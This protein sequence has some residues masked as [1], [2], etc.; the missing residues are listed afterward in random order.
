M[1]TP[2]KDLEETK[3]AEAET[4]A[5]VA[6]PDEEIR[7][8]QL[9][10]TLQPHLEQGRKKRRRKP[11]KTKKPW[12]QR[13]AT[14]FSLLVLFAILAVL[15]PIALALVAGRAVKAPEFLAVRVEKVLGQSLAGGQ[16]DLGRIDVILTEEWQPQIR[17]ERLAL[18]DQT[19]LPIAE[20]R[21]IRVTLSRRELLRATV[22][23]LDVTVNGGFMALRRDPDG[24]FD[25]ALESPDGR[26]L[27][28]TGNL[29]D[30]L[31]GIDR[32]FETPELA[33]V[34][35][36][37]AE[38]F[39][40]Q[41]EDVRA[42]KFWIAEGGAFE[43]T[44]QP[45]KLELRLGFQLL[46]GED[47][48]AQAAVSFTSFKGSR[49]AVLATNVI[50]L[51]ASD[52]ASQAPAL[53]W[54]EVLDAPVSGA[55]RAEIDDEGNLAST[56][57]T[58]D[59]GAGALK[60]TED[61]VPVG[62]DGARAYFGFD[63]AQQRIHF[64][65]LSV[66]TDYGSFQ[67]SGQGLLRDIR[68]GWPKEILGQFRLDTLELSPDGVFA[69]PVSIDQGVVELRLELNP[70]TLTLGQAMLQQGDGHLVARGQVAAKPGGWEVSV[71]AELDQM[72]ARSV[73]A[74][75]PL[76]A[77]GN[78]RKWLDANILEGVIGPAS[79]ALRLNPGEKPVVTAQFG[80][81]D[82]AVRF[83]RQMPLIT[84]GRG[85]GSLQGNRFVLV[86]E[87]GQVAPPEGGAL[88]V[89]GSVMTLE[90]IS[91]RPPD[92]HVDLQAQGNITAVTSLLD[93]RPFEFF[94]KAELPVD[95]A[96]GTAQVVADITVPLR[97][98][99]QAEDVPFEARATLRNMGTREIVP[100]KWVLADAM[101]VFANNEQ[102]EIS[103]SGF[104]AKAETATTGARFD[105]LWQQSLAPENAGQSSV[106]GQVILDQAFLDE[107]GIALPDGFLRGESRGE[108]AIDLRRDE[109]PHMR[110]SSD[111]RGARL[112]IGEIGWSKPASS[113]GSLEISGHLGAP[114]RID[115]LQLE[116][117]G[118]NAVG[119]VVLNDNNSF[120]EA[121]FDR[122]TVG[123]WLD[124]PVTL[125]ARNAGQSPAISVRGGRVDIR[126]TTFGQGGSAGTGSSNTPITLALD[127][128]QITDSIALH[129]M[130]GQLNTSPALQGD[131]TG[132]VNGQASVSGRLS[133]SVEGTSVR[134]R[135]DD[136]GAVLR[137]AGV[138]S[139]VYGG[140]MDMFL[141][142]RAEEGHY[143]GR[144]TAEGIKIRGAPALAEILGAISVVGLLQQLNGDGIRFGSVQSHFVLT[145]SYVNLLDGSAIGASLGVSM[146]GIY[147]LG[148]SGLDLRGVVSPIYLLN[149]VGAAVSRRREGLF[150][151]NYRLQ[152]TA[153]DPKVR[154]NPL[155]ILTPGILRD[156]FRGRAPEVP[157]E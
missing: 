136:S 20:L 132:L 21:N 15:V 61:T 55:L 31:D 96:T 146:E 57:G 78:T 75:W 155:S 86:A 34:R 156:V 142:P 44:Q 105:A 24:L 83:M 148:T 14:I 138:F 120:R 37:S 88:Q 129:N 93:Q 65:E 25:M 10:A 30:I 79:A 50:G 113:G 90:D 53:A 51:P 26:A 18:A 109:A 32:I 56:D 66:S 114:V 80:F 76:A 23:P 111:L 108:F 141:V 127:R 140:S 40:F 36:M 102:L 153:D 157:T 149:G 12:R 27:Q 33:S 150:G 54:L 63:P 85:Y 29:A 48:P 5:P 133:P 46:Y 69:A 74:L 28:G 68:N 134:I 130:R 13:H 126:R 35:M 103:G 42:A 11:K 123:S 81:Q 82:A 58:L 99:L 118:L 60:P 64:D 59:I 117:N 62:F 131:F 112:R 71:D 125:T 70:F 8:E 107:F 92:L 2:E 94:T 77:A 110:L 152:G 89:G 151:F 84:H 121:V 122:V 45:D 106:S 95:L 124:A 39:T 97:R 143:D 7:P 6:V 38:D 115:R 100:G 52:F 144:L 137:A 87:E 4:A 17:I 43:L 147:N 135:S 1:T 101:Q 72:E 139:K 19:N 104:V 49:R 119:Q 41:Y 47:K 91:L 16:M 67:M 128:L 145:P 3:D 22:A 116:S 9:M 98:D 73:V 154:V